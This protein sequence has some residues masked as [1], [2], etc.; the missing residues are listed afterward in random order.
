MAVFLLFVDDFSL[1]QQTNYP[2]SIFNAISFDI[3]SHNFCSF[4]VYFSLPP[5]MMFYIPIMRRK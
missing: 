4:A 5:T 2:A 3:T 1:P